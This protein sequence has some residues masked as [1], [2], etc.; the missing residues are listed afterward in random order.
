M[1]GQLDLQAYAPTQW[2]TRRTAYCLVPQKPL[3]RPVGASYRFRRFHTKTIQHPFHPC[4][5]SAEVQVGNVPGCCSKAIGSNTLGVLPLPRKCTQATLL[6]RSARGENRAHDLYTCFQGPWAARFLAADD[7]PAVPSTLRMAIA[8]GQSVR[9]HRLARIEILS[10]T[11]L[12]RACGAVGG[13]DV[14][15]RYAEVDILNII[16]LYLL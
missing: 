11:G 16:T 9:Y 8:L 6:T 3:I 14:G 5:S 7:T 10:S 12:M 15:L 2:A 13:G 4:S 1:L